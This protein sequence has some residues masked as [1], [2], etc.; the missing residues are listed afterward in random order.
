MA[1]PQGAAAENIS[2]SWCAMRTQLLNGQCRQHGRLQATETTAAA[3]GAAAVLI[4]YGRCTLTTGLLVRKRARNASEPLHRATYPT[5][6]ASS[7]R[8][9]ANVEHAHRQR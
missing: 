5:V 4:D 3:Q 2:Y 8:K 7:R 9:R 1:A 6:M